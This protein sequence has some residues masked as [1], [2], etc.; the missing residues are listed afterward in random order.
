RRRSRRAQKCGVA[1]A[2]ALER[3]GAKAVASAPPGLL[4][5]ES[6][7]SRPS[8]ARWKRS[9]C[10]FSALARVSNQSAISSKPSSRAVRAILGYMSVYLW[11]SLAIAARR[12]SLVPP[13]GFLVA[14]LPISLRYSRWP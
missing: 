6:D 12:L 2:S 1:D 5:S 10:D 9:A 4:E 7:Q 13:I 3:K 14:G 11:V 8:S